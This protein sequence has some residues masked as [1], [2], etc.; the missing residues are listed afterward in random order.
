MVIQHHQK[1]DTVIS[2]MKNAKRLWY[3]RKSVCRSYTKPLA[4]SSLT[5]YCS[6][7]HWSHNEVSVRLG[8]VGVCL[9]HQTRALIKVTV[10]FLQALSGLE[11]E[12]LL[13]ENRAVA[14]SYTS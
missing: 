14:N 6:Q 8:R 13:N 3:K 4:L 5:A 10:S 9:S 11:P 1:A 2:D 12:R 7:E